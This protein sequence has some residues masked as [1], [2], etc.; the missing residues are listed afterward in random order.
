M[1]IGKPRGAQGALD[2]LD[3][4]IPDHALAQRNVTHPV[5]QG[6][7]FNFSDFVFAEGLRGRLL[8]VSGAGKRDRPV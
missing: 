7:H 4:D 5:D 6:E 3:R 8:S 2:L 1:S